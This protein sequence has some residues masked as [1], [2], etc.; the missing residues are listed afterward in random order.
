MLWINVTREFSSYWADFKFS[1]DENSQEDDY[2]PLIAKKEIS[3]IS[4]H[5]IIEYIRSLIDDCLY[6]LLNIDMFYIDEWWDKKQEKDHF[7]HQICI[8][9]YNDIDQSF[10]VADF[11]QN[12]YKI[13]SIKYKAFEAAYLQ[14]NYYNNLDED[15]HGNKIFCLKYRFVSYDLDINHIKDSIYDF[16][17]STDNSIK[18]YLN[19]LY[20]E[21]KIIYGNSCFNYLK[22]YIC[23]FLSKSRRLD[24]RVFHLLYLFNKIMMDR[25]EFLIDNGLISNNT[26]ILRDIDTLVQQ[27]K[28]IVNCAMKYNLNRSFLTG[29]RILNRFN[30]L[31]IQEH[32][33]LVI[34]Y[35]IL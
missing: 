17:E 33:L 8:F 28:I 3:R 20:F 2:C 19:G 4:I 6:V 9:G 7:F 24:I 15:Y 30:F 29:S 5:C 14:Y 26:C 13:I 16:L 35:K 11:F 18:N 31:M 34:L 23:E 12:H 10:Q 21:N 25:F 22:V 32:K 1:Y 27:S